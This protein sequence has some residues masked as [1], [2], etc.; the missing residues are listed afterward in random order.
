MKLKRVLLK[1]Q[2]PSQVNGCN[3][4]SLMQTELTDLAFESGFVTYTDREGKH[5]VPAANALEML[6]DVEPQPQPKAARG[7]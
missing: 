7:G 2:Y 1:T 6:E 4:S 5:R 3:R